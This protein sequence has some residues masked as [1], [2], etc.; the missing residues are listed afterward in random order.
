MHITSQGLLHA[1]LRVYRGARGQFP[2][3]RLFR[4]VDSTATRR[5]S[6]RG[7]LKE[8]IAERQAADAEIDAQLKRRAIAA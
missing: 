3:Q 7:L 4:P 6:W 5:E 2:R 1:L 8:L